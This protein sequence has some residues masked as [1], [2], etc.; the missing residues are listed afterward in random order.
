M[1]VSW[2][3]INKWLG[4]WKRNVGWRQMFTNTKRENFKRIE[5]SG[6]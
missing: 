2:D 3:L 6:L 4:L 5:V 1:C